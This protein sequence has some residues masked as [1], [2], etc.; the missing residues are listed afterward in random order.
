MTRP[1][2]ISAPAKVRRLQPLPVKARRRERRRTLPEPGAAKH[3]LDRRSLPGS[4]AVPA[5]RL[6]TRRH[7]DGGHGRPA[8]NYHF[9][10]KYATAFVPRRT[11]TIP[12]HKSGPP[13]ASRQLNTNQ[14]LYSNCQFSRAGISANTRACSIVTAALSRR[15]WTLGP[16]RARTRLSSFRSL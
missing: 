11:T 16:R 10:R 1:D 12:L 6:R 5:A 9:S 14:P 7:R 15:G 13:V 2:K 3:L 8:R 4:A